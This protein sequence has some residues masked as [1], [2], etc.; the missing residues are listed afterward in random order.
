MSIIKLTCSAAFLFYTG[1]MIFS[2]ASAQ[3]TSDTLKGRNIYNPD[4]LTSEDTIAVSV[5]ENEQMQYR[6]LFRQG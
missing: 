3:R 6:I 2:P 1:L 5:M 4:K